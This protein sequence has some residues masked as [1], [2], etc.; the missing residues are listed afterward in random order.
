[1][2]ITW[3]RE[4]R[5]TG[6]G[7]YGS[8]TA[9]RFIKDLASGTDSLDLVI[10][11]DSNTGFAPAGMWGYNSGFQ[12]ALNLK[13]WTCYGTPV[14]PIMDDY[15][16]NYNLNVWSGE[17][18]IKVANGNCL[19]GNT[20][21]GSTAFAGWTPSV[22]GSLTYVRYGSTS[23]TPVYKQ[24]WAYISSTSS[25]AYQDH[26][27]G[28]TINSSHPLTSNALTIWYR[29]RFGT[30][31][32][33]SGKFQPNVRGEL[34]AAPWT[35]TNIARSSVVNTNTGASSFAVTEHSFTPRSGES[36]RAS[37]F[38]DGNSQSV[39][40]IAIHSQSMYC[41]RKGW[42]VHSH[43]FFAGYTSTEIASQISATGSTLLQTQLQELRERQIAAGGT[44]RVLILM[45]SGINGND[46][47]STWT[48]AHI[49]VWNTYKAA[50]TALGYPAS[51]LAI[52][53][54]VGVPRNSNDSSS[55]GS[56]GNLVAVRAAANEMVQTNTDMTVVD[57]KQ[58]LNYA[59]CNRGTGGGRTYYSTAN[60][61]H[62]SG[63]YSSGSFPTGTKDTSDGYTIAADLILNALVT[64]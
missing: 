25:N 55:S 16:S 52:V 21:G 35:V 1:M 63:G 41:K 62:L 4:S 48:A 54:W 39:G 47:S 18:S 2:L 13:G 45:H 22:S 53:S 36:Q 42:A 44:G 50:W 51:D 57:I 30:F 23:S 31:A 3:R 33:G 17:I 34:E 27:H 9:C 64:A 8:E 61:V 15:T 5:R 43:G 46:T 40:P 28:M 37:P 49:S 26:Y 60:T 24:A 38:G 12:E 29:V 14:L 56:A 58:F 32:T 19:N 7:V 6:P 10:I 11:G 20:S 59:Q